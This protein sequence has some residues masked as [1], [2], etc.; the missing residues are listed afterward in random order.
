MQN[1]F[2]D[3]IILN[4]QKLHSKNNPFIY[5]SCIYLSFWCYI[6]VPSFQ[7][8]S[9]I[10]NTFIKFQ[11]LKCKPFGTST[12]RNVSSFSS[13]TRN[14]IR[15]SSRMNIRKHRLLLLCP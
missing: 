3:A 8:H 2:I 14:Y 11:T 5:E 4:K 12:P 9:S 10:T 7:K 6:T 1:T 15:R 13:Q